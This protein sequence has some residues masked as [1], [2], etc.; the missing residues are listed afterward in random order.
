MLQ[1][2]N[3]QQSIKIIVEIAINM[4]IVARIKFSSKPKVSTIALGY[5]FYTN[6][7]GN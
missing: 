5:Y 7:G 2:T 1:C 6:V 4:N 3:A